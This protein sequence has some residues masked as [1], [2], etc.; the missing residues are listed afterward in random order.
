M[1]LNAFAQLHANAAGRVGGQQ[2]PYVAALERLI[3]A[4][5]Q[6]PVEAANT[7]WPTFAGSPGRTPANRKL[8]PII[9]PAWA[10]P[11]SI[12]PTLIAPR[13]ARLTLDGQWLA[14]DLD[15][16]RV[17]LAARQT[18]P[19]LSCFPISVDDLVL[20]CDANQIYASDWA[21]G[22]PAVT[23]DGVLYQAHST[24][25]RSGLDGRAFRSRWDIDDVASHGVPRHTLTA[26]A[27]VL[28]AHVGRA[29]AAQL[30]SGEP[31]R[32][33]Q[34]VGLDLRRDG[35]LAFRARPDDGTWSFDGVPVG[36]GRRM[37]VA[38][39]R[40]DVM[41]R[42]YVACFDAETESRPLWRTAIG[43]AEMPAGGAGVQITH[44]L[45]TLVGDRIYFNTNLGL[46]AAVDANDGEICWIRHVD[47]H[48]SQPLVGGAEQLHL[49]RDPSPC[50]YHE[51]LVIVAPAYSPDI[52]A[53]DALT[54]QTIWSTDKLPGALHVLG[55]VR[56]NLIVSGDR[57]SAVDVR[58][59]K[60]KFVW[61]EKQQQ[62]LRGMGRGIV[63]GDEVF[64]PTRSEIY[65]IHGV[66]GATSRKPIPLGTISD[67]GANLAA[68]KGRLVVA[69]P[70]KLM[71]FGPALS[72]PPNRTKV[73]NNEPLTTIVP[74]PTD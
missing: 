1:E 6:W 59:G 67:R 5:K 44:N 53:L 27:G 43:A 11:V 57:L 19:P 8:G 7:G 40:G 50:L 69:G 73:Q 15:R 66:T 25:R 72:V 70:D 9:G 71:L 14:G 48:A 58:T 46:I 64:W 37:F 24:G 52:F 68:A 41:P 12:A 65:V 61:P 10:A 21:T 3:S 16:N 60:L 17:G 45:L 74:P 34:L 51:G 33:D 4:A 47:R 22:K 30:E 55:V 42:A 32:S 62:G 20:Y 39:R 49:N 28:Y 18:N 35:Q 2:G 23:R 63:A 26:I 38:M 29:G 56:R 36:D 13:S 31:S 54:G